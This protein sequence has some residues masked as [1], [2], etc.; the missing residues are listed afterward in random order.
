[1]DELLNKGIDDMSREEAQIRAAY[2]LNMCMVSISQIIDYD[3]LY[4]LEQEYDGI[5]NNLNLEM[6]PKDEALLNIIKQILDT[7][8]FFRIQEGD[9]KFIDKE[10]QQKMKNAIWQAVPNFGLIVAGGN[11]VSMAISL[12]SQVGIGYMNYRRAKS[13]NALENEKEMWRL[14]RSAMEQ[15]N[16]LRRELFDTAWR[17]ATE[18]KFPDNYRLTE[19]Q[20]KQYNEILMDP[21]EMRKYERLSSISGMFIAYPPFWYQMGSTANHIARNLSIDLSEENRYFYR[22]KALDCFGQYWKSNKYGLLREDQVASACALEHIDLLQVEKDAD[23]INQLLEKAIEYSGDEND[24]LQ[25]CVVAY[26]RMNNKR[27]AAELLRI[28]VNEG[29]NT[30]V[31]AQLLSGL[32][33]NMAVEGNKEAFY[34]YETLSTRINKDYL[35][36]MPENITVSESKRLMDDFNQR[37]EEL[38]MRKFA[39]VIRYMINQY[40]IRLAKLIPDP[41][42]NKQH[43]DDYYGKDGISR[44]LRDFNELF[45]NKYSGRRREE[46]LDALSKSAFMV[47]VFDILND[48]FD[49]VQC[50]NCIRDRQKL[51]EVIEQQIISSSTE[52]N[53]IIGRIEKR[54]ASYDDIYKLLIFLSPAFFEEFSKELNEQIRISV[55]GMDSMEQYAA[56]DGRLVDFCREQ[57][58]PDPDELI[59]DENV[60]KTDVD[61]VHNYFSYGLLGEKGAQYQREQGKYREVES[62]ISKNMDKFNII[63]QKSQAFFHDSTEFNAYFERSKLKNHKEILRKTLAVYDDTSKANVDILFTVDGIVPVIYGSIKQEVPYLVLASEKKQNNL[64]AALKR[65]PDSE[66]ALTFMGASTLLTV[67]GLTTTGI[68]VAK[69]IMEERAISTVVNEMQDMIDDICDVIVKYEVK[70]R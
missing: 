9:R 22:K 60:A 67:G 2:A 32:Y 27:K 56:A 17:L 24:I 11:P 61:I 30:V 20:I 31:N 36:E 4:I 52:M 50:M 5:L 42:M 13:E 58:I 21:D 23:Q 34:L 8:T 70:N 66:K 62:I 29:Y 16:G 63:S 39:V 35:V 54:N 69:K 40:S 57:S 65:L 10:Y 46:Y 68:F 25:L 15:F 59:R 47:S 33:V 26:L 45:S 43:Q 28:L 7:I 6:M 55:I 49:A 53:S 14:Q 1:M 44:R 19:K 12:A 18:Y 41:D 51:Q 3:D 37:Q 64:F 48:F 38:L